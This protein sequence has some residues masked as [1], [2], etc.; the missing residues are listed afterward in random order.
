MPWLFRILNYLYAGYFL[1]ICPQP[2][3]SFSFLRKI[4]SGMSYADGIP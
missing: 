3:F 2:I 1:I 4:I